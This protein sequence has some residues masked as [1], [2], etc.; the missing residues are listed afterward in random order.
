MGVALGKYNYG[1]KSPDI[2]LIWELSRSESRGSKSGIWGHWL[3]L[4]RV[5]FAMGYQGI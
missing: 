2:K 5:Q 1:R 3:L 4:F